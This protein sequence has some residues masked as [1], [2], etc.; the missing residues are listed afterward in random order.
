MITTHPSDACYFACR[1]AARKAAKRGERVIRLGSF[2]R[3]SF[4]PYGRTTSSG[5]PVGGPNTLITVWMVT[6]RA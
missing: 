6:N 3:G 4:G 1:S 2:A 5:Q